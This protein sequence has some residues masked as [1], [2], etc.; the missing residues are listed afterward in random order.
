MGR[1]FIGPDHPCGYH[2]RRVSNG[3][4]GVV[5]EFRADHDRSV[6]H[7]VGEVDPNPAVRGMSPGVI[8]RVDVI[9][10]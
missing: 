7:V 3:S 10:G 2:V 8:V 6:P 4:S 9:A 1:Q 5:G